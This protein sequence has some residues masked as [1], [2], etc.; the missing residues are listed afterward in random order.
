MCSLTPQTLRLKSLS[1]SLTGNEFNPFLFSNH[2][3]TAIIM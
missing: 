3:K 2:L 1:S